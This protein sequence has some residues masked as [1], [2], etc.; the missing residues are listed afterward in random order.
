M[1]DC[2]CDCGNQVNVNGSNLRRG[3]TKSCG[4]LAREKAKEGRE[5][6]WAASEK[7]AYEQ[8][9]GKHFGRLTPIKRAYQVDKQQR[10]RCVWEC[11]CDCGKTTTVSENA[12]KVGATQSCGCLH[13]EIASFRGLR[14][15]TGKKFGRLVVVCRE[16]QQGDG[17]VYWR[18]HCDCGQE[19]TVRGTALTGALTQS[20]GCLQREVV[21]LP[22]GLSRKRALLTRY[23]GNAVSRNL[24]WGLTDDQ[25]YELISKDCHYCGI[26]PCTLQKS[27]RLV[28]EL[29]YNGVDRK[30]NAQGYKV[31]NVVSCC[32]FCQ[33]AK[34]SLPYDEFIENMRRVGRFQLQKSD[35]EAVVHVI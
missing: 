32:K 25:F 33:Y 11:R 6:Y 14:D 34:R 29:L 15:L 26:P 8:L 2:S 20:C 35:I 27:R 28:G 31:G 9:E 23:K 18:V 1:W 24:S 5:K 17:P 7:R 12:L 16:G 19:K 30:D 21:S 10:K 3:I 4:C 13:R 22:V